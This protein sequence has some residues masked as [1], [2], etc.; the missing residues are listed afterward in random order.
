MLGRAYK[1][2]LHAAWLLSKGL[3]TRVTLVRGRLK[4]GGVELNCMFVA[5]GIFA[6]RI[7]LWLFSEPPT[8]LEQ[9]RL[10]TPL[11][12]SFLKQSAPRFDI[13]IT[14]LAKEYN[15]IV[16]PIATY[17]GQSSVD[18]KIDTSEGWDG[19]RKHVSRRYRKRIENFEIRCGLKCTVSEDPSDL[20]TFYHQMYLPNSA[21]RFGKLAV[22]N[23]LSQMQAF[24]KRDGFLLF[25]TLNGEKIAGVLCRVEKKCLTGYRCGV[26][27]GDEK[28]LECGAMTAVYYYMVDYAAKNCLRELDILDSRP[29]LNDGVYRYKGSW[30]AAAVPFED[31]YVRTIHYICGA[32]THEVAS[33]FHACPTIVMNHGSLQ[34]I[35]GHPDDAVL[36]DAEVSR[37]I[38]SYY[39]SGIQSAE[40]LTASGAK[41]MVQLP[42]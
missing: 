15:F 16:R 35:I 40:I 5:P 6:E 32:R 25:V 37:I 14:S 9:R 36:T 13:C 10:F 30:G 19:V 7:L 18:Q 26:L 12:R 17:S 33:F 29:F 2:L 3:L 21:V 39:T 23:E 28:L 11:L 31:K 20:I 4:A 41:L 1:A 8:I 24:L 22:T 42:N 27:N 34:A 38:K